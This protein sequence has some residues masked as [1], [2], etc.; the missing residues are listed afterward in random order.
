ML[1]KLFAV[2]LNVTVKFV[3]V[4]SQ[5]AA[6]T[7]AAFTE[8]YLL[9]AIPFAAVLF[10]AA[11]QSRN[12]VFLLLL[13]T[14]PLS[15]EYNFSKTLGTDVPDEI[16]MLFTAGLFIV[17]W[18]YSPGV[19]P[20]KALRHPLLFLLLVGLGWMISCALT[21]NSPMSITWAGSSWK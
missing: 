9:I 18:I 10:Y 3:P 19:V 8:E 13:F 4:L 5:F 7:L 20:N 12:I 14:L 1:V 16:L 2:L 21:W 17:Y 6:I 15:F 11:W